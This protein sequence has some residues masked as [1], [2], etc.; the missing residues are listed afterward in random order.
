M[1][2]GWEAG[3]AGREEPVPRLGAEGVRA[4]V[5]QDLGVRYSCRRAG[6]GGLGL[7]EAAPEGTDDQATRG[8]SCDP[9]QPR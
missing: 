9:C 7:E 4:S 8:K 1:R 2:R 3:V 6:L 5:C